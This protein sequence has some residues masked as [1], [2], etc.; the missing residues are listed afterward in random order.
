MSESLLAVG[1]FLDAVGALVVLIPDFDSRLRYRFRRWTPVLR[2]YHEATWAFMTVDEFAEEPETVESS[3][4]TVWPA[5][6]EN[7]TP[8]RG[9]EFNEVS[10]VRWRP[11]SE[12]LV[13]GGESAGGE[14]VLGV[15]ELVD[16]VN[17]YCAGRYRLYGWL[18]LATGFGVQFIGTSCS[19]PNS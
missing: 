12:E 15:G 9:R 4:R 5:I 19:L 16:H 18:L 13:L 6:R 2:R 1:L 11:E 3:L 17:S 8:F 14:Y 7:F 10:V